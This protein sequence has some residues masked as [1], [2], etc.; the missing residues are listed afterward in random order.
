MASYHHCLLI[1]LVAS[2]SN[3][4]R[5]PLL[6]KDWIITNDAGNYSVPASVPGTVHTNLQ[7]AGKIPDPYL[8]YNDVDL[9]FLI[10]NNW[11]FSKNFTLSSDIIASNQVSIHFDQIDTV[12][13]V[14]L[15]G[16]LL[17]QTNSMFIPYTFPIPNNSLQA[18]NF[19]QIHFQS[20]VLYA[21]DQS[22]AYNDSVPPLQPPEAQHGEGHVQF[23]RKEP[24]SF[25]WDWVR[26]F[27]FFFWITLS[28]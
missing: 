12:A 28:A 1:L 23:M 14:T 22:N 9:R 3:A 24:C 20:P 26:V 15:N 2:F 13:N 6:G 10:Y 27:D 18:S 8:G 16:Y 5:V 19:L 11:V 7:A 25:S 17:G 21:L 4:I